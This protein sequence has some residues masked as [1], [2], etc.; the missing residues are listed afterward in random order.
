MLATSK[1]MF[2]PVMPPR[3]F[4]TSHVDRPVSV[5]ISP[6]DVTEPIINTVSHPIFLSTSRQVSRLMPGKNIEIAPQLETVATS[7]CLIQGLTTHSTKRMHKITITFF[8]LDLK[9]PID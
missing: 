4:F 3:V 1:I 9:E 5:A 6:S 8:S 7:S 2:H